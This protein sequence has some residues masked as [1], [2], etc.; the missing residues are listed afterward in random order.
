M[1]NPMNY[2]KA[3]GLMLARKHLPNVTPFTDI[4]VV[5]TLEEWE[6]IKSRYGKTAAYRSDTLLGTPRNNVVNGT[7][8]LLDQLPGLIQKVNT[9]S[10]DGVV[11]VMKSNSPI[12]ARYAY[13]G[14]FNLALVVGETVTIEVVGQGFDGHELTQGLARHEAWV[15]KWRD[16]EQIDP[17]VP[18]ATLQSALSHWQV[19][20]EAYQQQRQARMDFLCSDELN[21]EPVMVARS[22]PEHYTPA[23]ETG[24]IQRLLCQVVLP[25]TRQQ[26]SL[27]RNDLRVFG[28]QGNFVRGKPQVWELFRA[29][30]WA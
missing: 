17:R 5:A 8:G 20:D 18:K 7:N 30:A 19:D 21:Y 15:L 3:S 26:A 2:C 24:L 16:A 6:Q 4:A 10:P 23:T 14:G 25:L 12:V 1:R 13:S 9:Q 27:M 29:Q 11:L 28:V 22:V